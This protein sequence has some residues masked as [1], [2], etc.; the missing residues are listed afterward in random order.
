MTIKFLKKYFTLFT[1][2][3]LISF[4]LHLNAQNQ[5]NFKIAKSLD[6]Y[7]NLIKELNINYVDEIFPEKLM[8]AGIDAMLQELDPYTVFIPESE[9]DEYEMIT[10]GT[11]GGIGVLIHQQDGKTIISEIYKGFPA[12]ISGLYVGDQVIK[13][14]DISIKDKTSTE[15]S[16]MIKGPA[17]TPTKITVKR[18][19]TEELMDFTFNREIVKIENV[20]YYGLLDNNI[21]YIKLVGF[22]HN[23]T[24]EVKNALLDLKSK[25]KLKGL[26]LDLRGNGG[27]LMN[28]AIDIVNLFVDQ[29]KE[30]LSTKGK[31]E[32]SNMTYKTQFSPVDKNIS[33][34][35][36][37]DNGSASSSE[38]VAGALQDLD[39]AVI[40]GQRSYGK[41]LVQNIIPLSY[42]TQVKVTIAKYYIP[43]G[44]CIQAIDYSLKNEN[45]EF[46]KIPDS[47]ISEFK[48][49]SGRKVYDG[50]GI[51]P[52][53]KVAPSTF[54]QLT[55]N[56]YG[57]F[58]IFDYATKFKSEHPSIA[59][60]KDFKISDET[61]RDFLAYLKEAKFSYQTQYERTL[62][63][64][65]KQAEKENSFEEVK[66]EFAALEAAINENKSAEYTKY[67]E[68][69]KRVLKME[70]VSRY[71][72]MAGEVETSL[73]KDLDLDKAMEV[74]IN[75][76][77]YQALLLPE[78]NKILG[79]K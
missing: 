65:K 21:G 60:A 11:Y 50:G 67:Q 59:K 28:E 37:I 69:I 62:E 20:P 36:L 6:I 53:I 27:G 76:N 24:K 1:A 68:E 41:G 29:N 70:I 35:V 13:I 79:K 45:D 19:G 14:D 15:V 42:N 5:N 55:A 17:K 4:S 9:I 77:Q 66:N 12:Q 56:L 33:L 64:L 30:V 3:L 23:A 31:I 18:Y 73:Y 75:Q 7:S 51:D 40:I 78:P 44:R 2:I 34:A 22:S 57:R 63:V 10:T 58:L 71:Y 43:S 74:L 26:V 72:Y 8:K 32:E 16:K 47:L 48:T 39:R 38:I 49:Q 61:Y 52:D 54:S 25:T 46:A